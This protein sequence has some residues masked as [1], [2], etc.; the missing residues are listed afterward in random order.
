[1]TRSPPLWMN[2]VLTFSKSS[3]TPPSARA[4]PNRYDGWRQQGDTHLSPSA[5]V[6]CNAAPA[7]LPVETFLWG[8]SDLTFFLCD[9]AS[10]IMRRQWRFLPRLA[11]FNFYPVQRVKPGGLRRKTAVKKYLLWKLIVSLWSLLKDWSK[12]RGRWVSHCDIPACVLK[13]CSSSFTSWRYFHIE[14]LHFSCLK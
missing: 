10:F 14:S 2:R 8:T 3:Q 9:F 7:Q 13:H 12:W 11:D 4:A 6:C 5:P 1:M